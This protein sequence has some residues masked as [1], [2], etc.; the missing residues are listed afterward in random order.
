ME[1]FCQ[2]EHFHTSSAGSIQAGAASWYAR[3]IQLTQMH[4][5]GAGDKKEVSSDKAGPDSKAKDSSEAAKQPEPAQAAVER[6]PSVELVAD[7]TPDGDQLD[8]SSAEVDTVTS[9]TSQKP[10]KAEEDQEDAKGSKAAAGKEIMGSEEAAKASKPS[11]QAEAEKETAVEKAEAFNESAPKESTESGEKSLGETSVTDKEKDHKDAP[12]KGKPD[13]ELVPVPEQRQPETRDADKTP[14]SKAEQ[15]SKSSSSDAEPHSKGVTKAVTQEKGTATEPPV[16]A[17]KPTG[18][19]EAPEAVAEAQPEEH[20]TASSKP[21]G[22]LKAPAEHP[23]PTTA[24]AEAAKSKDSADSVS[25]PA[26]STDDK[27][28]S[29][30]ESSKTAVAKSKAASRGAAGEV[31]KGAEQDGAPEN[32]AYD[33][34]GMDTADDNLPV[35]EVTFS[36]IA[37]F[38][39]ITLHIT[40]IAPPSACVPWEAVKCH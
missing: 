35:S 31:S 19:E 21:N 5:A 29:A 23:A 1:L 26:G 14:H 18:E 38:A 9:I 28:E 17:G 25:K 6:E 10:K 8:L 12:S 40:N 3:N 24:H 11:R 34:L 39:A 33:P 13:V 16:S 30:A 4:H 7:T 2:H 15:P 32:A 36:S 27:A 37:Q 20:K 22:N